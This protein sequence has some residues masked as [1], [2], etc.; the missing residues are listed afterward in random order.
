MSVV[1][2]TLSQV[3][4]YIVLAQF[5]FLTKPTPFTVFSSAE[6]IEIDM[7]NEYVFWSDSTPP[8]L[9]PSLI[10]LKVYGC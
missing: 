2:V 5:L 3:Q 8:P 9:S 1:I 4:L 6:H 10:S 7:T